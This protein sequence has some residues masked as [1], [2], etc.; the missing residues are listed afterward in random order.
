MEVIEEA[1]K[2]IAWRKQQP[3]EERAK[4]VASI[5]KVENS[6]KKSISSKKHGYSEI[7]G[8]S[9]GESQTREAE[10]L[11]TYLEAKS[12]MGVWRSE[13]NKRRRKGDRE[14]V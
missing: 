9:R 1:A 8:G 6:T 4:V 11:R 2:L 10:S 5:E 14:L 3:E 12:D 7:G 13:V